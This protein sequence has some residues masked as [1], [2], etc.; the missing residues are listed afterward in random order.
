[1]SQVRE[2]PLALLVT[3]LA[4]DKGRQALSQMAHVAHACLPGVTLGC[5]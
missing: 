2:H 5:R 1:M 4:V 3:E